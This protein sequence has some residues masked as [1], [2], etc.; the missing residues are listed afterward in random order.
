MGFIVARVQLQER[1]A[2]ADWRLAI[3][4]WPL[5]KGTIENRQLKIGNGIGR[6]RMCPNCV[7]GP[8]SIL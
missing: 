2:I 4:N 1:Q 7:V 6:Y 3:A 8:F 5:A